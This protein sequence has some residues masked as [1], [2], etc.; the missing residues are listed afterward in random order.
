M[1][2]A[3]C[4]QHIQRLSSYFAFNAKTCYFWISSKS[5][6]FVIHLNHFKWTRHLLFSTNILLQLKFLCRDSW[7]AS[8]IW[9]SELSRH[10]EEWS[11][12]HRGRAARSRSSW[13]N[14]SMV[15]STRS[16]QRG[17][18]ATLS[19]RAE[20]PEQTSCE[21]DAEER[22]KISIRRFN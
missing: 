19:G 20:Q 14:R 11:E 2:I 8:V 7:S 1:D 5:T 10:T 22:F 13:P 17:R 16:L 4:N 3:M 18:D 6:V 12:A 15:T 9:S 21:S